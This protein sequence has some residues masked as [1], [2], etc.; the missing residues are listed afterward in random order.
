MTYTMEQMWGLVNTADL[1][2]A[3]TGAAL[4]ECLNRIEAVQEYA[5]LF[6]GQQKYFGTTTWDQMEHVLYL[7]DGEPDGADD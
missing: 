6:Y 2:P 4:A 1:L 7:L 5:R 3:E